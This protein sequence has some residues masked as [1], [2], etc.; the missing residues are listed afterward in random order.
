[1]TSPLPAPYNG[2]V[3]ETPSDDQGEQSDQDGALGIDDDQLPEDLRPSDDNPLAQPADDDVP[4]DLLAQGAGHPD[5]GSGSEGA[6]PTGDGGSSDAPSSEASSEAT[7]GTE[8]G[9]QESAD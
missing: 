3:S 7:P 5:S 2:Q 1:V 9:S 6:S 8:A 4:D